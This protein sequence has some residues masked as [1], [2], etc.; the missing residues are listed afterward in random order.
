MNDER[1]TPR[2]VA[3]F[4]LGFLLFAPPLLGVFDRNT[5]VAGVPLLWLYLFLAWG[6]VIGLIAVTVRRSD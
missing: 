4:V 6:L 3:I 1:A 5:R 2:L